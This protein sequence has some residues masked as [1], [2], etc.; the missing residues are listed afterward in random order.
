MLIFKIAI[1]W[2]VLCNLY[3]FF[4]V[5]REEMDHA[6]L[7]NCGRLQLICGLIF[8]APAWILKLIF[9]SYK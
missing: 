9:P 7:M 8:Y 6:L 1:V 3:M 4:F 2:C 5:D